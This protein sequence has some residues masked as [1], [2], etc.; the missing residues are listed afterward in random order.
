VSVP[1]LASDT[2]H[3]SPYHN[4]QPDTEDTPHC[5][6]AAGFAGIPQTTG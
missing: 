4:S 2:R 6:L 1:T 5:A 3:L